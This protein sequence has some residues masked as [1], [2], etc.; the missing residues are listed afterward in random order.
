MKFV[1][2]LELEERGFFSKRDLRRFFKSDSD[3]RKY[4]FTFKRKGRA[5]RRNKG[6]YYLV[7]HTGAEDMGG[8]PV[9]RG[10]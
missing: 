7:P 9:H 5:V 6:K 3:M 4:V 1:S 10:G 8:A 2:Y